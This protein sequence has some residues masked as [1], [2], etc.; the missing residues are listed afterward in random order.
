MNTKTRVYFLVLGLAI[1]VAATLILRIAG[2]YFF[3]S[4]I[5]FYWIDVV[6]TGTLYTAVALGIMRWR[7]IE[8]TDWLHCAVCVAIPGMLGEI[9][10]MADFSELMSN[11]QPETAGRYAAFLFGGYVS[12]VGSAWWVSTRASL[13]ASVKNKNM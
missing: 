4:S 3:E 5:L 10:I 7:G 9:P 6:T 11:M 12:L 8:Q 2:S 13:Q 1:W